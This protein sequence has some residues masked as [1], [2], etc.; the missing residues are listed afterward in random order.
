MY[1]SF[2]IQN[3]W[4]NEWGMNAVFHSLQC[5]VCTQSDFFVFINLFGARYTYV[6]SM[7]SLVFLFIY[8]FHAPHRDFVVWQYERSMFCTWTL[9]ASV[10][11]SRKYV[12]AFTRYLYI[13]YWLL[14]KYNNIWPS[15]R[16]GRPFMLLCVNFQV[17]G[18]TSLL[19]L[20]YPRGKAD[21][22]RHSDNRLCKCFK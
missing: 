9:F 19:L 14:H 3:N 21:G 8:F 10:G 1:F 6:G 20:L 7:L 11:L 12:R 4:R 15:D 5:A 18:T 13:T 22:R 2:L 16:F 17:N